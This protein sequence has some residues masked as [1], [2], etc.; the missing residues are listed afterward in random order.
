MLATAATAASQ[1]THLQYV[2][3]PMQTG[4]DAFVSSDGLYYPEGG[5]IGTYAGKASAPTDIQLRVDLMAD[6]LRMV[7]A[8][9]TIDKRRTT[10]KVFSAPEFFFRGA[11][12]A[13]DMGAEG[14][15][16]VEGLAQKLSAL[17]AG[18]EWHDWVCFF[19]S[20]IGYQQVARP[21]VEAAGPGGERRRLLDTYN[22][23]LVQRG[24]PDGERHVHFKKYISSIDFLDATP[25]IAET[26]TFPEMNVSRR[27][28]SWPKPMKRVTKLYP[29]MEERAREGLERAAGG[30]VTGRFEMANV[31]F[32]L[33]ICLDHAMGV[34]AQ[35]LDQEKAE[36]KG[37]GLVS[38]HAIVSAGMRI[39]PRHVRVPAGGSA[40]LADGLG[41]GAQ[42]SLESND[43]PMASHTHAATAAEAPASYD[44]A[45]VVADARRRGVAPNQ[46]LDEG[47]AG[48]VASTPVDVLGPKWR[49]RVNGVFAVQRYGEKSPPWE[50]PSYDSYDSYDGAAEE[51]WA[52]VAEVTPVAHV[53]EA[54]PIVRP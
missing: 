19:G 3:W 50:S 49:A 9:D 21:T 37:P 51:A 18:A 28:W 31:S 8:S 5:G 2:G 22:F 20:T 1:Y 44:E 54:V 23:A 53:F 13:Y 11:I 32:C 24:G 40:I 46:V 34:C 26:V 25:G 47:Y 43:H 6:A 15:R 12:G 48:K 17:I 29:I 7:A 35:A 36:G 4:Y 30:A 10:L 41:A 16:A 14:Q 38:V 33:D 27:A 42:Q 39:Q 45:A 52:V